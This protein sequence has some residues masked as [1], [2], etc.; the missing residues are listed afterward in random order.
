MS[1]KVKVLLLL[2]LVSCRVYSQ[3]ILQQ[4]K[5]GLKGVQLTSFSGSV[6]SSNS[7]LSTLK[8]C[9][10]GRYSYFKDAGWY[11]E[12]YATGAS[13]TTITGN[14]DIVESGSSFAIQYQ[15]DSGDSGTFPIYLQGDGKV[16]IGGTAFSAEKGKAG[17]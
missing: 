7:S 4:W 6:V 11:V 14:W 17:C 16:N 8:L 5:E 1:F 3:T 12:G 2:L 15:A 10:N 13:K 9:R